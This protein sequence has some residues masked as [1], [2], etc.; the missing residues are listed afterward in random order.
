[1]KIPVYDLSGKVKS[2][3][4]VKRAFSEPVRKDLIKRAVLAERA[5]ERAPYGADP[6]AGKKTSAHYHGRRHYRYSMMNREMSRMK[7]IHG[8]GFLSF[9]ARFVPQAVK[10]R[11]AHPPKSE[12]AWKVKINKKEHAK[13]V[14]S[15]ISACAERELLQERGH[16]IENVK[17]IP[18]VVDDSFEKLNRVRDVR[19]ALIHMG[20]GDEIE[21]VKEK[22]IRSGKGK[23]RGRRYKKKKGPVIIVDN[24][25][26]VQKAARN[27]HGFEVVPASMLDVELLAPGAAPGRLCVWTKGALEKVDKP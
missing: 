16:K 24:G 3:I 11:K 10:G 13:A 25:E 9:R 1:M 2:N 22:K 20:L 12:K 23:M 6:S 5:A 18:L 14:M 15:A 4:E 26:L 8:S 7:R 27:I 17:H 21:R 19:D